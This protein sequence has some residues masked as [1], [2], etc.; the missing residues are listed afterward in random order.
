[1]VY[2]NKNIETKVFLRIN[3]EMKTD[4]QEGNKLIAAFI[5]DPF[6][7]EW[8]KYNKGEFD[9]SYLKYHSSWALLMPVFYKFKD[10]IFSS[11]SERHYHNQI[12]DSTLKILKEEKQD[13]ALQEFYRNM[14]MAIKWYNQNKEK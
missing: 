6:V 7:L 8:Q 10:L 1:M 11:I 9:Y 13:V 5:D 12:I 3:L 4:I 14:V 2:K